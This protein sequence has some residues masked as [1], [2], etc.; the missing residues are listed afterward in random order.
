MVIR[1]AP[2][3]ATDTVPFEPESETVTE[4]LPWEIELSEAEADP[5]E[6]HFSPS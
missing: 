3:V 2:S 1:V 4:L 5:A 6:V